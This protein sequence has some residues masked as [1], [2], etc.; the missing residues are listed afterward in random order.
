[1][2][3]CKMSI[4]LAYGMAVYSLACIW[5]LVFTIGIGTPFK[6]SLSKKQKRIKNRSATKRRNIF[7]VGI[8]VSCVFLFIWKPFHKCN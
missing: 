4:Y 6:D 2:N 5:Y 7:Y 1:M 8:L 3:S